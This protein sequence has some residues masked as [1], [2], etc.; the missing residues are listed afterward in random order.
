MAQDREAEAPPAT[1]APRG[2]V[3]ARAADA[4]REAVHGR[5]ALASCAIWTLGV[6]L[7]IWV[8]PDDRTIA[9]G[10]G[11]LLLPAGLVWLARPRLLAA[12]TARRLLDSA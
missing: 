5:L 10:A 4:A 7:L 8:A 6:F 1:R 9:M 11:I 2:T 3:E 12:E